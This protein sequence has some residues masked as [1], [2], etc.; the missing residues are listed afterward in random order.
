MTTNDPISEMEIARESQMTREIYCIATDF[1]LCYG[2]YIM[3]I[4]QHWKNYV[5]AK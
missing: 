5:V 2:K 3:I 4:Q 1:G